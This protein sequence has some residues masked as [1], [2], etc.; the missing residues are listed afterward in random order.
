M[1][2]LLLSSFRW[3]I[4]NSTSLNTFIKYRRKTKLNSA[5]I[6]SVP[7]LT[8]VLY[9]FLRKKQDEVD[10]YPQLFSSIIADAPFCCWCES[11]N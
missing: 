4:W 3:F 6:S 7:T 5:K 9:L 10:S 8:R 1:T 2:I 11:C